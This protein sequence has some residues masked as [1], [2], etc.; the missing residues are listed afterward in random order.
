MNKAVNKTLN[1]T[2]IF[3]IYDNADRFLQIFK[4]K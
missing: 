3:L 2:V 4:K 1:Q